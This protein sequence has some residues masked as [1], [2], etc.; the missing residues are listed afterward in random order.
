L[1]V[2]CQPRLPAEAGGGGL[3]AMNR[4]CSTRVPAGLLPAA[5]AGTDSVARSAAALAD[6]GACAGDIAGVERGLAI[7]CAGDVA[8]I[9]LGLGVSGIELGLGGPWAVKF[10]G[11]CI[12]ERTKFCGAICGFDAIRGADVMRGVAIIRGA[13]MTRGADIMRAVPRRCGHRPRRASA[14]AAMTSG[15]L[16]PGGACRRPVESER[17]R[18]AAARML[19]GIM[20][21]TPTSPARVNSQGGVFVS[22]AQVR[23]LSLTHYS[24][25]MTNRS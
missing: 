11:V 12:W 1:N 14:S 22:L 23:R 16:R 6:G 10:R 25:A 21:L 8:G 2:A 15:A 17:M 19:D 24:S 18:T 3:L 20:I 7:G 13:D 9:E 4:F 5:P